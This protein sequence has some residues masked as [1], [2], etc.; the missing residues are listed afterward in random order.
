MSQIGGCRGTGAGADI[1]NGDD[2][3]GTEI[4]DEMEV[5]ESPL[6][7]RIGSLEDIGAGTCNDE[8]MAEM[9]VTGSVV[10]I[11]DLIFSMMSFEMGLISLP[12]NS[13]RNP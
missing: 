7:L 4:L 6:R 2:V 11:N 1:L 3:A 10:L 13:C 5:N 8:K 9:G 12:H